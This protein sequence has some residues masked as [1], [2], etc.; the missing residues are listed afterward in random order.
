MSRLHPHLEQW[1]KAGRSHDSKGL[2]QLTKAAVVL[3]KYSRADTIDL[4]KAA[5]E[6]PLLVSY[7]ADGTPIVTRHHLRHA[8]SGHRPLIRSG[9]ATEEF[10]CQA[11]IYVFHVAIGDRQSKALVSDTRPMTQGKTSQAMLS[12]GLDV[13][14][15]PRSHGHAGILILRRSPG[16]SLTTSPTKPRAWVTT[17]AICLRS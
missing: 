4:I 12:L 6:K 14:L 2:Q 8:L 16:S 17:I 7:H 11:A 10:C 13:L 3:Q 15:H 1:A 5:E 9:K